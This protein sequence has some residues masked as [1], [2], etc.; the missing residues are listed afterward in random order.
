MRWRDSA[1]LDM[2]EGDSAEREILRGSFAR[3]TQWFLSDMEA[4]YC[5]DWGG[6]SQDS[7]QG[8]TIE[9]EEF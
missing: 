6:G 7:P 3:R 9:L 4:R 2:L 5:V 1:M 8:L